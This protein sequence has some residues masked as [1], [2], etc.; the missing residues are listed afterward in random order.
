MAEIAA[1]NAAAREQVAKICDNL[2][3]RPTFFD[4][5]DESKGSKDYSRWRKD[6]ITCIS[7][8]SAFKESLAFPGSIPAPPTI[9][10][11]DLM[12]DTAAGHTS[13]TMPQMRQAAILIV[14]RATLSADGESIKLIR[15]CVHAGGVVQSGGQNYDQ[16]IRLLDTRWQ[17]ADAPEFD[18]GEETRKLH[19]MQ[20]PSSFSVDDFNNH[21]NLAVSRASRAAMNPSTETQNAIQLRSTW[22][23]VIADPPATSHYF[24]AAQEARAVTGQ[25]STSVAHR[26]AWQAA[27]GTAI[28]R[29]VIA[30][31]GKDAGGMARGTASARFA[32]ALPPGLEVSASAAT[33]STSFP[34]SGGGSGGSR[35]KKCGRCPLVNGEPVLHDRSYACTT[36]CF[37]DGCGSTRHAKHSCWILN[38]IPPYAKMVP[39]LHTEL[40][41]LRA[42]QVEGKFDWRTTPTNIK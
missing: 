34:G 15:D 31:V 9:N 16:A 28:T 4:T 7:P 37:C 40:A 19:S 23:Y 12:L 24:T 29:L 6:L 39:E 2:I 26:A 22:W 13:L 32:G 35:T 8:Y 3:S 42:L 17:P 11:A 38:G 41:R 30:G 5:F 21:F 18:T 36:P 10:D 1:A 14:M 27:M 33:P 25:A 20:W